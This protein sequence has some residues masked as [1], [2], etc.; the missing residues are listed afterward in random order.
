MHT[1][2]A[3]ISLQI[4]KRFYAASPVTFADPDADLASPPSS[5][6][7]YQKDIKTYDDQSSRNFAYL[8]IGGISAVS[9]V[10]AKNVVTD[11]LVNLSASADVL[12]LA[13]VEVAMASIPE[14]KNVV[15]KVCWHLYTIT[16]FRMDS[17]M[18]FTRF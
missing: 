16:L 10:T 11:Y 17:L 14:G 2:L 9:A 1:L 6:K 5:V 8:M 7:Y 15:I 3:P 18:G 4:Q 12:A 13:K